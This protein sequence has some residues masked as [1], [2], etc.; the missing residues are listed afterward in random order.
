MKNKRSKI[1]AIL[2][3]VLRFGPAA[4]V[5]AYYSQ[6]FFEGSAIKISAGVI[7][8]AVLI[9]LRFKKAITKVFDLP[10]G[11]GIALFMGVFS[12]ICLLIGE[13][14]F[15]VSVTYITS[16]IAS[17]PV[18]AWNSLPTVEETTANA[19]QELAKAVKK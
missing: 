10:G 18:E 6:D 7:F 9:L 8:L 1:I 14:I 12:G 19:L 13:Q 4:G 16:V 5:V 3:E 15:Y 17:L 11:T 2:T